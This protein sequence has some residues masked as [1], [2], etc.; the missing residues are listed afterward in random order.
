MSKKQEFKDQIRELDIKIAEM[1]I[2]R[3]ELYHRVDEEIEKE[4]AL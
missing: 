4:G 3:E 1:E 2:L